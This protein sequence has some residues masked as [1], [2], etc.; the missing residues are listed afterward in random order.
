ME[1]VGYADQLSVAPEET[2]RFHVSCQRPTYRADIVRLIHGDP[3]PRGPG[4][5]EELVSTP[6]SSEYPGRSQ[7]IHTGSH[8]IVPDAPLLRLHD[9][10]TLQAWIYPTTPQKGTQGILAKWSEADGGYGL[11]LDE[12]GVLAVWL[13]D[14]A[15]R[16]QQVR[17]AT[18]L[19]AAE[20]YFVAATFD[21][22]NAQIAVYQEPLRTWPQDQTRATETASTQFQAIHTTQVDCVMAGLWQAGDD[23]QS[24]VGRHFNGKIDR[25]C[26]FQ[27]ALSREEL[28]ALQRGASPLA[29]GDDLVA[30]WNF[31]AETAS[32][33]IIDTSPHGLYGRTVNMPA[34][35][36]TGYNWSGRETDF[37]NAP[38]EYGAIHFHDDDLEDVGWQVDFSWTLP[39][40]CKSGVYAARLRTEGGEDHIPFFV[41]PP[42]GR[43]TADIAFLAPTNSYLAYANE[44]LTEISLDLAPNQ[45]R[46]E[47]TPEDRYVA[48]NGLLSLYDHHADGSGV[49]YS[50][51]L[52]PIL[53]MRPRYHMRT[54]SCP[55]QF[56]ADLHLID[57]LEAK[58]HA[59][60]VITDE[61]LHAEGLD[62]LAPYKVI[63]TGS[64]PEYWSG[65]M[66]D[67]LE[68]YLNNGGRLMYLGGNGFYWVTSFAPG[69]PHVVEVRRWGGTRSWQAKPGEYHH[70]TTGESGGLWRD[71]GR[72]PQRLVGVGFTTQGFDT[73]APYQRQPD[74]F[75]PRAAFI[76]EGIGAEEAIGDFDS[77]V[78]N[79]GAAGFELDRA[80]RSLGTPAHALVVASSS[81]HSDAYQHVVE[82][83]LLSDSKQGG[84]VNPKVRADMVYFEYPQGGAVF[85]ASSIAW[86]GA[87]S[88]NQYEN[89]VS[90]ITDNVLR[91]FAAEGPLSE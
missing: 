3:N 26:V 86:D 65:P 6:V 72:T 12:G 39:A 38:H 8:V 71:R 62:L 90:R 15:G 63:I 37:R 76:F 28:I 79:Y 69:R 67:A 41:R 58:G 22:Q 21:A 70:S 35:A 85:S 27:R 30:A 87:L 11:V 51:R 7:V 5:K 52:R 32:D 89:T 55:H 24:R 45:N 56:P 47:A 43:A 34:R 14:P 23:G 54:L 74:S 4:F 29:F 1:I 68:T 48:D 83:V 25:P 77:L 33:K 18:P 36:M 40:E 84:T 91:R 60:D 66:L 82:E 57:W 19:R 59:H 78:L 20:W 61:N 73:S 17:I 50:S 88:H 13:S 49:C 16:T 53:N 44:H 10:F 81:G 75:D 42:Q 80:E 2:I 46:G 64:H 9:S 31:S